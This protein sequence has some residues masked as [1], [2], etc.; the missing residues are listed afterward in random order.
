MTDE[1]FVILAGSI[2]PGDVTGSFPDSK[3][4][5]RQKLIDI[6]VIEVRGDQL[7][8][9]L[10]NVLMGTPSGASTLIVGSPSNGWLDW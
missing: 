9:F 7:V 6:G 5:N 3:K 2:A 1:G 10:E 8:V 4:A